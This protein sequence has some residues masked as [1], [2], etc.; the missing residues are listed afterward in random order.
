MPARCSGMSRAGARHSGNFT[1]WSCWQ[2]GQKVSA[3]T[4][5][6]A[7]VPRGADDAVVRAVPQSPAGAEGF[8]RV[9]GDTLVPAAF[10]TS[11]WGPGLHGRLIG[12]LA[13]GG[14][15]AAR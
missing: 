6:G 9:D 4:L 7:S 12:G 2:E 11:P 5:G 14:A 1:I 13:A 3:E 15:R 10:A 8:F